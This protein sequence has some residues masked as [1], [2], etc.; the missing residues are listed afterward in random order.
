M[1]SLESGTPLSALGGGEKEKKKKEKSKD[2]R[3]ATLACEL[4]TYLLSYLG[5]YLAACFG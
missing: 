5:R 4:P 3:I 2:T 1:L